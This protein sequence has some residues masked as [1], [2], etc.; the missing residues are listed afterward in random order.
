MR[1]S[2]EVLINALTS[3][4]GYAVSLAVLFILTPLIIKS[5]GTEDFGLW[6]LMFSLLGLFGLIDLGFAVG[7]MKYV[8]E[9]RGSG[10][11][12]RR[13][14]M[15]STLWAV[16]LVLALVAGFGILGLS[17]IFNPVF[18]IPAE[19]Q[20]KAI[21]LLWILAARSVLL[22]IPLGLF[23]GILFGEQKIYLIRLISAFSVALYGIV[24][25]LALKR[26]AD[27]IT[28][29]WINLAAM[30]LEHLCYVVFCFSFVKKLKV[31]LRLADFK[32]FKE[33]A[34][35]SFSQF[36]VDIASI[37]RLRTDPM[38]IKFFMPLPAVAL[39]AVA[40]KMVENAFLFIKQ[41]A[42]ILTP[43]IAELKGMGDDKRIRW[44]L[45]ICSKY[46]LAPMMI[47]T[48]G[49]ITF[50]RE[51]LNLWVGPDFGQSYVLLIILM[52][53]LAISMAREVSSSILAMTGFHHESAKISGVAA[54]TNIVISIALIKPL[55]LVG[56]ALGTLMS[57]IFVDFI[58]LVGKACKVYQVKFGEFLYRGVV[59]ALIPGFFQLGVSEYVKRTYA[60]MS[61]SM[62]VVESCVGTVA[63]LIVFWLYAVSKSEKEMIM[64]KIFKPKRT[65]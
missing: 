37:I 52:C 34:S 50:G 55:G 16:Y 4:L 49:S 64:S 15:V 11:I 2:A 9:C 40:L 24:T 21:M 42:N 47:I 31:S 19:Q 45:I 22:S 33:A 35:F 10:D 28:V 8:A 43:L 3:V 26:H 20:H 65:M 63:Y 53:S 18:S 14:K 17:A 38:I 62:I 25:W 60:P 32:L 57:T 5:V 51:F 44:I 12:E 56:V 46:T 54:L 13:N 41:F 48:M 6:S 29:A 58:F 1:R 7:V 23:R 36:M 59:L 27:I 30:I 61:I 39:Y